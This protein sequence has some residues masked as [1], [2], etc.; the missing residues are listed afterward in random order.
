MALVA[1]YVIPWFESQQ[2]NTS[3]G[4]SGERAR[5]IRW[6]WAELCVTN[7][8]AF[9]AFLA[10]YLPA[11][12]GRRSESLPTA[13][14][15]QPSSERHATGLIPPTA[16]QLEAMDR[17]LVNTGEV[18]PNRLGLERINAER[19]KMGLP[20]I[21]ITPAPEGQEVVPKPK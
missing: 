7:R 13:E 21:T 18:R 5:F 3:T 11:C 14:T 9:C 2:N 20:P 12:A 1:H 6:R 8:T 16:E 17:D 19:A 10:I 4:R 15:K